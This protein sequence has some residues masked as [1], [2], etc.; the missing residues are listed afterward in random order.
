MPLRIIEPAQR[1]GAQAAFALLVVVV[2]A[3]SPLLE[4]VRLALD[5]LFA[6]AE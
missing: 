5:T 3:L 4:A 1:A 6:P 2:L